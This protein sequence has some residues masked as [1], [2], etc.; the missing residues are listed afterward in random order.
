MS[1]FKC[2]LY[3]FVQVSK[4]YVSKPIAQEI[5]DKAAPFIVWLQE[6]EEEESSDDED[7]VEVGSQ[8]L[9]INHLIT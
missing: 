8:V 4:K 5:H 2:V 6:A 3:V 1:W 7:E 9:V